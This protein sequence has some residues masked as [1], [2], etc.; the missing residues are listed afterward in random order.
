[1]KLRIEDVFGRIISED[2]I[3]MSQGDLLICRFNKIKPVE[4][5]I[6]ILTHIKKALIEPETSIVA[7]PYYIDLSVIKREAE[8]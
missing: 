8:K 5:M 6:G 3:I 1:M 4:E 7:L 2:D